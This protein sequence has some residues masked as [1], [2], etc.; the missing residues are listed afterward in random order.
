[1]KIKLYISPVT[2]KVVGVIIGES[3]KT[4]IGNLSSDNIVVQD[5]I[6]GADCGKLRVGLL[7]NWPIQKEG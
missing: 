7:K 6:D 4:F 5:N 2:L 1:M 3:G